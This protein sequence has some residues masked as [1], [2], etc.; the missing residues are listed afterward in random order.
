MPTTPTD[1]GPDELPA[2]PNPDPP[3]GMPSELLALKLRETT[4]ALF[5]WGSMLGTMRQADAQAFKI[6]RDD[7]LAA[8]GR[9]ND[10]LEVMMI[11]QVALAHFNIGRLQLASATARS[12]EAVKTFGY[13]AIGLS[14]EFRKSVLTL[15]DYRLK[16]RLLAAPGAGTPSN[17]GGA[18]S[19][20][21]SP[22]SDTRLESAAHEAPADDEQ[23]I[24]LPGPAALGD[25]SAGRAAKKAYPRRS[26]AAAGGGAG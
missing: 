1:A 19:T 17:D 24:P 25:L 16:S 21:P 6:L 18:V 12:L 7:L 9:P 4:G 23:I 5:L 14:G 22:A 3:D 26:R 8:A 10:P 13:L 2:T 11:E 20:A 15:A